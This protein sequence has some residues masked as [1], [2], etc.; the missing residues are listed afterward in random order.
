MD[1]LAL[2]TQFYVPPILIHSVPRQRLLDRLAQNPKPKL[3][4]LSAPAGYGKTT[5]LSQ[6]VNTPNGHSPRMAWISLRERDNKPSRFW[7]YL[8]SALEPLGLT[9]EANVE[10]AS[11]LTED[12]LTDL[13]VSKLPHASAAAYNRAEN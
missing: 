8:L 4:L 12:C 9:N 7:N 10:C 11:E 3:V 1:Q 2:A 6:W 5:L 13:N